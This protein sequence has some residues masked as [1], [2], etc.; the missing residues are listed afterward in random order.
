MADLKLDVMFGFPSYGG[1]GGIA[2]EVPDIRKWFAK[3]MLKATADPRI[4]NIHELTLSDTPITMVRNQ[5]VMEARK[6]NCD[7]L[8]MVDSDQDPYRHQGQEGTED[9][10]DS[11]LDFVHD[12]YSRGPCVVGA[13][14]CG[15][16]N[17]TE[18]MYVF[19]WETTHSAEENGEYSYKICQ[20]PRQWAARMRGIQECAAL[21]TGMIMYDMRL[22]DLIE[23]CNLSKRDVLEK[24]HKNEISVAE[25]MKMLTPGFFYYEW[26]DQYASGKMSTEDVTN[27]RDISLA[28][29]IKL[30]YN[31]VYCNWNS[32]VGH[33]KPWCVRG[34]P[35]EYGVDGVAATMRRSFGETDDVADNEIMLDLG[36]D[37]LRSLG[38]QRSQVQLAGEGNGS[39]RPE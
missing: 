6:R 28:G 31:P 12:H 20:Y 8:V 32:P 38:I 37:N 22:F 7:I 39:P 30:G 19:Y 25:A 5:F 33:W 21:P 2:S 4:G 13:P 35:A 36:D 27:T 23:P 29:M 10:W 26:T 11:T 17:H 15:P 16:P 14:Y 3:T 1:N 18:N 9:W 24:L 34:R